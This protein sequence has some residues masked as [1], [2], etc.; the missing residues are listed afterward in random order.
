MKYIDP[1]NRFSL[2]LPETWSGKYRVKEESTEESVFI[3]FLYI[4][5]NDLSDLQG[6]M[7][8]IESFAKDQGDLSEYGYKYIG[9]K[10][11]VYYYFARPTDVQYDGAPEEIANDY[12]ALQDDLDQIFNSVKL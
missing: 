3:A 12:L 2:E 10:D 9:T 8:M 4:P 11:G 6:R 5:L 1:Q 7:F